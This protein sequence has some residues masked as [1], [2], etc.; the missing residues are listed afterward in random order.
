MRTKLTLSFLLFCTISFGQSLSSLNLNYLYD[1]QQEVQLQM[2]AVKGGNKITVLYQLQAKGDQ[3]MADNYKIEWQKWDSFNSREGITLEQVA[4]ELPATQKTTKL[5][6]LELP[7]PEKPWVLVAKVTNT[8]T[9]KSWNFIQTIDLKYPVTG[10]VENATGF[11]LR[12][13][14]TK[15]KEV[16]IY[17]ALNKPLHVDF[18]KTIFDVASPPFA[19]KQN[20]PDAFMFPDSTFT[21]QSGDKVNFKKEGLYLVQEDTIATEGFSFRVVKDAF[22]KFTKME[23]LAPPLIFICT[24]EE[25]DQLLSAKDDKAKFDNVIL[26]ITKDKDRAKTFMRSYFRRVELANTYFSSYKEGWKTDRGMIYLIFGLPDEVSKTGLK[27]IWYYRTSKAR[28][29]FVRTGSVYDPNH[30]TLIRDNNFTEVW[31]STIDLWRKSR[32]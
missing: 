31:F 15:S 24:K 8:S 22:P 12:P 19:E 21:I 4:I 25:H 14:L 6:K 16:T 5:G 10:F 30:F 27:E 20:K 9:L 18:H 13:F 2:E 3:N 32:Y 17:G 11:L 29:T 7:F 23:D 1:P 28:F 26:D